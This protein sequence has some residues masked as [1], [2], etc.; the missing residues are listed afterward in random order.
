MDIVNNGQNIPS[1]YLDKNC[2]KKL[3]KVVCIPH[4]GNREGFKV[5]KISTTTALAPVCSMPVTVG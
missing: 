2:H 3:I 5:E 1:C 4:D